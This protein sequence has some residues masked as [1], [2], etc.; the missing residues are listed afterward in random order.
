MA[1][2]AEIAEQIA[3]Q[4]SWFMQQNAISQQVGVNPQAFGGMG[5]WGL[6]PPRMPVMPP[7]PGQSMPG[8]FNYGGGGFGFGAGNRIAAMGAAGTSALPFMGT[9]AFGSS[10]AFNPIAGFMMARGAGLGAGAAAGVGALVAAPAALGAAALNQM[11][12]GGQQQAM[13]NTAVSNYGFANPASMTGQG[14]SRQDA[15]QISARVRSLSMIP[16]LM[17]SFEE[18]TRLLPQ[19]KQMGVMQGARDATEFGRRMKDAIGTI[20]DVSRII[21]TTMEDAA[22]FFQHSRS[23]GFFGR[24]D[25]LKNAM[26]AQLT[27]S[28]TGMSRDQVMAMQQQGASWGSAIGGSRGL[29]ATAVTNIAQRIGLAQMGNQQLQETIANITGLTGE[30]GTGAAAGM[31]ANLGMRIAGTGPGRFMLAGFMKNGPGGPSIDAEMVEKLK[32]GEISMD[33]IRQRGSRVMGDHRNVLAF[34][35]HQTRLAQQLVSSGGAEGMLALLQG[36]VGDSDSAGILL[37]N[38]FGATEEEVDLAEGLLQ[39]NAGG[40]GEQRRLLAETV[41]RQISRREGGAQ[42][43]WSKMGR[44]FSNQWLEPLR[45]V[46]AEIHGDVGNFVDEVLTDI[47]NDA[48]VSATTQGKKEF[49]EAFTSGDAKKLKGMTTA[50]TSGFAGSFTSQITRGLRNTDFAA[51]LMRGANDTGRSAEAERARYAAL[52]GRDPGNTLGM[53]VSAQALGAGF[54]T[55][56]D[57]E[58]RGAAGAAGVVKRLWGTEE[59]RNATGAKKLEMALAAIRSDDSLQGALGSIGGR[60]QGTDA[61]LALL[62]AGN[63]KLGAGRL[64]LAG[65]LQSE[66]GPLDIAGV[67]DVLRDTQK[68]AVSVF[69]SEAAG[70]VMGSPKLRQAL[71]AAFSNE[72]IRLAIQSGDAAAVLKASGG[73]IALSDEEMHLANKAMDAAAAQQGTTGSGMI[74][75]IEQAQ[76]LQNAVA[77][78]DAMK[79]QGAEVS[80]SLG[81]LSGIKGAEGLTSAV[82][83]LAGALKGGGSGTHKAI[84]AIVAAFDAMPEGPEKDKALSALP[85][86]AKNAINRRSAAKKAAGKLTTGLHS[87]DEVAKKTGLSVEELQATF[88]TKGSQLYVDD[89][90]RG[91]LARR[92]AYSGAGA[93]MGAGAQA[94]QK[95]AKENQQ[96]VLMKTMTEALI[97]IAGDKMPKGAAEAYEKNRKLAEGNANPG[98]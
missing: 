84:D 65:I 86:M 18:V 20:R 25:Q 90:V 28:V 32:R 52:M 5:G 70:A 83:G 44:R 79:Q 53:E 37:K 8:A 26:N 74:A 49:Q 17:T 61:A 66:G 60:S 78:Q 46:G 64:D 21:G 41:R 40:M 14:F 35:R 82:G 68:Q 67:N 19:L 75:S 9:M 95:E 81:G 87:L 76:G 58:S 47:A 56:G 29:G 96:L 30:E 31:M 59:F 92:G 22:Q 3:Q 72:N 45:K 6:A 42:G 63:A 50:D 15:Q 55:Q 10:P 38:K 39:S 33:E 71:K 13:L 85:P 94:A 91:E 57:V 2:S 62:S 11:V 97:A 43:I 54:Q 1:S 7:A 23:V 24:G 89:S 34:E 27:M 4:Q 69:G 16:E 12:T 88:K 36:A 93:V 98:G 73:K 51:F 80:S 77:F 48:V